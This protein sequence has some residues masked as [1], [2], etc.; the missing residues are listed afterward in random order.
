MK[1]SNKKIKRLMIA[2]RGEICRRIAI[3]AQEMGIETVTILEDPIPK[4]YIASHIDH[5]VR[6]IRASNQ[7]YLDIE[8]LIELTLQEQC[9]A[10][11]PGFGFLSENNEFATACKKA[12]I[13]WVG[14]NPESMAVMASKDVA[15]NLAKD[16]KVPVNDAVEGIEIDS[17]NPTLSSSIIDQA[18]KIGFPLLVKAAWGGGG[19]GMRL[20]EKLEDLEEATIRCASEAVSSFGNGLLLIERYLTSPRHIEVQIL[21]DKH[22][23]VYAIGDR[24]CSV[25]RR[26]QKII[27]EAPAPFINDK[28]RNAMHQAAIK[29]A[30]S[31]NYDST[32]T[33]EFM[34][35]QSVDHTSD[36]LQ[37]F[38]F[39][40]MNTRLQ[41]EHPVTEEIHGLDLVSWQ[42][43]VAS[44]EILPDFS[45]LKAQRHSIEARIY[46]EDTLQNYLPS[47]GPIRA[48]IPMQGPGVRWELGID[49]IDEVSARF[50]PMIAKCVATAA[51]REL[52]CQKL[53]SVLKKTV[54]CG[55]ENNLSFLRKILSDEDFIYKPVGTDYLQINGP[56]IT[57]SMQ[58]EFSSL[59]TYATG[60][61]NWVKNRGGP[62]VS[63]S[64]A[65]EADQAISRAFSRGSTPFIDQ[66]ESTEP[67]IIMQSESPNQIM[68]QAIDNKGGCFHFVSFKEFSS[69]EY[70]V[71]FAGWAFNDKIIEASLDEYLLQ[72]GGGDEIV[73][74][75]PGKIM[76]FK[77]SENDEVKKGQVIFILESMKMEFE[78][79]APRDGIVS[80]FKVS[81]GE[82]VKAGE[83]LA[84]WG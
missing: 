2:N 56:K 54:L 40:E 71:H 53:E 62:S 65:S 70:W 19:K 83:S 34:L 58:D 43:R 42:L 78:V 57:S 46:A 5:F 14:P 8:Q 23:N 82:Q 21:A 84:S 3:T 37:H 41:V 76:S 47:P 68:G 13:L 60:L 20:V 32:G 28:T 25:Q 72:S 64:T 52:A 74:P 6:P 69:S 9:D 22:H 18:K 44:G 15:R 16:A 4:G 81:V 63:S 24:D 75:V 66:S 51:S 50:D 36:T 38:F 55:P 35:D 77:I 26:H 39:L 17:N 1:K 67:K 10:L 12:G 7:I 80:R 59:Q 30:K 45:Q 33:V 27:E 31:V 79:K 73:A 48:F 11:H 49:S 61:I 29:L